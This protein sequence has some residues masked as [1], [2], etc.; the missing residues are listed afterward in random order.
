MALT[1]VQ[2]KLLSGISRKGIWYPDK[3]EMRSIRILLKHDLIF[4]S[5]D[6]VYKTTAKGDALLQ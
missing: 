3:K 5:A 2:K 6:N 4:E 1:P